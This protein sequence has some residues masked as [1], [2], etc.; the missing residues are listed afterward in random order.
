MTVITQRN[1]INLYFD[2]AL[3]KLTKAA[4]IA[5]GSM[6]LGLSLLKQLNTGNQVEK[7]INTFIKDSGATPAFLNYNGFP[8]SIC[9]SKNEYIVHGTP[10]D[11]AIQEGDV[12]SLDLGV[13]YQ[14]FCSDMA[15]T[16]IIGQPKDLKHQRLIEV[17]EESFYKALGVM[18]P[19]VTTGLIGYTI[20]KHVISQQEHNKAL[21]NV[22]PPFQGHGIG[23]KLHESPGIPN[24]GFKEGGL[25]FKVG[26]SFCIEPVLIFN[27]LDRSLDTKDIIKEELPS[28]F[29]KFKTRDKSPSAHYENHVYLSETG[30][31]ILTI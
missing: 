13:N 21:F 2:E 8:H 14:G 27:H 25:A 11:D 23:L 15:R 10:D 26:M 16:I 28:G 31:I 19:D 3:E 20:Q 12:I 6:D 1:G 29:L 7:E 9:Y 17:A 5:K 18:K 30:P 4:S 22:F 24:F